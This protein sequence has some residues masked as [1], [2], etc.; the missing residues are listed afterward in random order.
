MPFTADLNPKTKGMELGDMLKMDYEMAR[1]KYY[2]D[3]MVN[4][5]PAAPIKSS[6]SDPGVPF[7][8]GNNYQSEE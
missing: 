5:K 4:R 6:A 7:K 1:K 2:D 3:A 8:F